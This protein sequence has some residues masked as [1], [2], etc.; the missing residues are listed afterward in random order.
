MRGSHPE[1]KWA[2][3]EIG[4]QVKIRLIQRRL[5]SF[6]TLSSENGAYDRLS[7]L[8]QGKTAMETIHL[9]CD[10][11]PYPI[12]EGSRLIGLVNPADVRW[13]RVGTALTSRTSRFFQRL[14]H[15]WHV[16]GDG[17]GPREITCSCGQPFLA[18][19]KFQFIFDTGHQEWYRLGQCER[20]LA[21]YWEEAPSSPVES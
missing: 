2:W 4:D 19:R 3:Q 5:S 9:E 12:V 11:P 6:V 17:R 14:R 18:L 8:G 1:G 16:P 21:I 13:S 7:A 10:A 15:G 20:C